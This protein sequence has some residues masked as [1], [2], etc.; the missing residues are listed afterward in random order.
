MLQSRGCIAAGAAAR[1]AAAW[2]AAA[3]GA[4]TPKEKKSLLLSYASA[5]GPSA[6]ECRKLNV[7][8]RKQLLLRVNTSLVNIFT[9]NWG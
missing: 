1:R 3:R 8:R 2:R 9:L 6:F 7:W 5:A 4:A